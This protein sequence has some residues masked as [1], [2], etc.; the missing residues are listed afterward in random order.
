MVP[1]CD[2]SDPSIFR[3]HFPEFGDSVT[4]PDSQVQF[5]LNLGGAMCRPGRWCDLRQFGTELVCAHFLALHQLATHGGAGG[6]AGVPGTG[7]G[8]VQSK[9]VSK[10]SVSYDQGITSVEGAGP[11]NYTAYGRQYAWWWQVIG[12]PGF[13]TLALGMD[14]MTEGIVHTWA[15]GVMLAWGS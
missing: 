15:R 14:G 13:E 10:V 11:W 1:V 8:V 7:M 5:F 4:Y 6:G 2:C 12:A 3:S 9:S